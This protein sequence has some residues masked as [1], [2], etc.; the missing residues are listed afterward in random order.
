MSLPN[1]ADIQQGSWDSIPKSVSPPLDQHSLLHLRDIEEGEVELGNP[2]RNLTL[3]MA[4]KGNTY[5]FAVLRNRS[6]EHFCK[7]EQWDT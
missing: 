5:P 1:Q 2:L 3:E 7:P 6:V 4:F